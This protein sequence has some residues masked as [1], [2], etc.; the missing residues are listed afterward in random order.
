RIAPID[1]AA[2]DRIIEAAK[3]G[4]RHA[5][6]VILSDYGKGVLTDRVLAAVIAAANAAG[7]PVIVDPKGS[8]YTRYKGATLITPNRKEAEEA[9]GRKLPDLAAVEEGAGDLID[10]AG[11]D[12]AVITLGAQGIYYRTK[13]GESGHEPTKAR[14]VFD[15]T[16]AGDTVVAHLALHVAA[17]HPLAAA[18]ALANQAAGIVVGRLGTNAVEREELRATLR[19]QMHHHG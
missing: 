18:V 10:L 4:L 12:A 11:L 13:D 3:D 1:G 16:G 8:D 6:V 19:Q 17:G 2:E 9:L 5:G 14:A 7:R 15:V